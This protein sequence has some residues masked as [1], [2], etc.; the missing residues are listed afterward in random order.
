M[1]QLRHEISPISLVSLEDFLFSFFYDQHQPTL[2]ITFRLDCNNIS[3][4]VI[5]ILHRCWV[6]HRSC[7]RR[8]ATAPRHLVNL[9]NEVSKQHLTSN[10]Y[11]RQN[12]TVNYLVLRYRDHICA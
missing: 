5:K 2:A 4:G 1:L 3:Y 7:Q 9:L 12:T 8:A 11:G 6:N 10:T